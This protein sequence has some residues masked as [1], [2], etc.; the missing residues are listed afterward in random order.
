MN[1]ARVCRACERHGARWDGSTAN[2]TRAL[3]CRPVA[4]SERPGRLVAPTVHQ[5]DAAAWLVPLTGHAD[6]VTGGA[7]S[8]DG[9]H[10][11]TT[12]DDR[13][14]QIWDATTGEQVAWQLEQLPDREAA[15]WSARTTASSAPPP[16]AW[17]RLAWLVPVDGVLTP[18]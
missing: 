13:T 10:I 6:W 4:G 7:F 12:S 18:L 2:R 5:P 9:T 11:L 8:P 14:A 17:R 3:R 15:V 1:S 16:G